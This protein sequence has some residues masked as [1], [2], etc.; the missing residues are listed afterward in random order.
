MKKVIVGISTVIIAAVLMHGCASQTTPSVTPADVEPPQT[1]EEII[2]LD[3]SWST[4]DDQ[5]ILD[6]NNGMI[7]W[8][9]YNN[10]GEVE[11]NTDEYGNVSV[12]GM[13][14]VTTNGSR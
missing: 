7:Y 3:E 5:R 6:P 2:S 11:I 13:S 8:Y 12:A 14:E 10:D 9:H 1:V 4:L